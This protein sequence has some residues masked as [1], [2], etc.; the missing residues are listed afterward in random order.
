MESKQIKPIRELFKEGCILILQKWS[1]FR[2]TLDNNPQIL[3]YLNDDNVLEINEMLEIL[4]DDMLDTIS[5]HKPSINTLVTKVADC[6]FGFIQDYFQ[7]DLDDD[8][9]T[10]VANMLIRLY[11]ELIQNKDTYLT[12]LREKSKTIKSIY[13]IYFPIRGDQKVVFE[14]AKD[15]E[16]DDDEDE[17]EECDDEGNEDNKDDTKTKAEINKKDVVMKDI[18]ND[19][20]VEVKKKKKGF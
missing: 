16:E 13:S 8:S 5:K 11:S 1:S 15:S 20:F 6:L 12:Q 2:I 7:V 3:T 4:Y 18:D 14:K 17:Y 19:G 10:E 9:D